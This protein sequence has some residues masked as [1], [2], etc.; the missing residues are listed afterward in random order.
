MV[1]PVQVL[2][3]IGSNI[4]RE[5][6][7]PAALDLLGTW[8]GIRLVAVSPVYDTAPIGGRPD[9]PRFYNAAALVETALGPEALKQALRSIEAQLGR[10][11][12]ADKYAPRPIDLDIAMY[13][14]QVLGLNGRHIPDPEIVRFPHLALPLAD[15][16]PDWVHPELG[17]TLRDIARQMSF[18]EEE[19]QKL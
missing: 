1:E 2:I 14:R 19:I 10:R 8:P 16:A 13:G 18:S 17:V 7:L 5:Q 3:T 12:V 9:Q 4:N 6:N 11:R 15:I